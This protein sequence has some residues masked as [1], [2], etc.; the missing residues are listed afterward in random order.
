MRIEIKSFDR[1]G[2]KIIERTY[3]VEEWNIMEVT[4]G[5]FRFIGDSIEYDQAKDDKPFET[6]EETDEENEQITK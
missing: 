1:Y 5:I 3:E 2:K 4:D 6:I